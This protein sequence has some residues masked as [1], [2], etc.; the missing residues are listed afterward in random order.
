LIKFTEKDRRL[1]IQ[2]GVSLIL[3]AVMLVHVNGV[4]SVRWIAKVDAARHDFWVEAF[5]IQGLDERVVI[6]DIDE[7]SLKEIGR[8]P[9]PRAQTARM[10]ANLF[11][12]YGVASVGYDIVFA[13][14]DQSSGLPVLENLANGA[15][16][17]EAGFASILER[18]RPRLDYD[19]LLAEAVGTGPAVLGLYFNFSPQP[20]IVGQL[21]SPVIDCAQ[22]RAA[23]IQPLRATG[24][25]AN[26]PRLQEKAHTAA[27]FNS[28]PDF[29]GVNRRLPMVLE[30]E[31][32]CYGS[33]SLL[34]TQAGLGA[35]APRVIPPEGLRPAALD[36][37][38]IRVPL[39][40]DAT[41]IMPYRQVGAFQYVSAAD[42]IH[43]RAPA[44]L[45]EGRVVLIGSTAPGVMDLRVTPLLE[46]FPG[47][48]IHANM[49]SAILDSSVKW[50]PANIAYLST[51]LIISLGLLLALLLPMISPIWAAGVSL[52]M[53]LALLG[54]DLYA[55]LNLHLSLP[56]AAPLLTVFGL[57]VLN[58]SY[59][60]FVEA[61][62]KAQITRL[63]GQYV[64]PELVDEMAK[65]PARYSLRGESR[66]MTV[67]FSD[68]R[69]FTSISEG[70]EATQLADMLNAYLSTMT[71]IVQKQNG[72]IDKY[73]GDAIMAFWGAPLS[74]EMHARDAVLT[75]LAMQDV[76][77]EL[78][79]RLEASG[80]PAVKIGVG[81]NT[82][83]MNVGNM[84]S[85]FRMAYTVMAD[86]VNLS[87][88]L[89]GLT[90]QYGVGILAGEDTRV[91]CP[92]ITFMLVDNVRVKGKVLPVAIYEPLG[93][94][95]EL[96]P[97]RIEEA[98]AFEAAVQDYQAK[99]WPAARA[100][101]QALKAG[102]PRKLYDIYLDRLDHFQDNPPPEDWD[103]VYTFT[104]K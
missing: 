99:N 101:L 17:G 86:A 67:L 34:T 104:S 57:F 69:D 51:L 89:E 31:G 54:F 39:D 93:L 66:V 74:D 40:K 11:Q 72:T 37:D 52:A 42:I 82:G 27:F 90:K 19:A 53:M 46:V 70:L 63:F 73:I 60:F 45:L 91:N 96:D 59:G 26:L 65:D 1:L 92:E 18:I 32:Q 62:S 43:S 76:L 30:H 97:A 49:I 103:G 7:K 23:G 58:M 14:P 4:F 28:W 68:I 29:D 9:W 83:R 21:P 24:Y 64:P 77:T 16:A 88:R 20:E 75:A 38:G 79:P 44:N 8:W 85:K 55:W 102:N 6:V 13:E 100:K 95:A 15:L 78:N 41:A 80:W 3:L 35:G 71:D 25:N 5:P 47:V 2:L 56:M 22:L 50:V 84:G 87:S 10:T 94:T 48:E 36:M 61:R 81:V 12:Q 33:L 98:Q